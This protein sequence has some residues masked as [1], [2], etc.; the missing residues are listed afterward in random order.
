MYGTVSPH[1]GKGFFLEL[2]NLDTECFQ[3]F[4]DEFKKSHRNGFHLIFLDNASCHFSKSLRVAGNIALIPIPPY[5]PELNPVERIWEELK[6]E[7]AWEIFE[8]LDLLS[9]KISEIVLSWESQM[10]KNLT[11]YPYIKEAFIA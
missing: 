1:S 3:I 10:L 8:N 9:Q 7:I 11:L 5:S 6:K 4:L 2:P